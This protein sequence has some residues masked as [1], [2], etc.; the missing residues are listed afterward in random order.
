MLVVGS[1]REVSSRHGTL[2][3]LGLATA[4]KL[5]WLKECFPE[6][7]SERIEYVYDRT[8]KRV[9]A[10]RYLRFRDLIVAQ[11]HQKELDPKGSAA[12]LAQAHVEGLFELPLFSHDLKQFAARVNLIASAAPDLEFPPYDMDA[13]KRA[14]ARAFHGL[15]LAKEAQ[16]ADLRGAIRAHLA[17]EQ[18]AWVDELAPISIAWPGEKKLKLLYSEEGKEGPELQVKLHECFGAAEHPRICEGR[19]PVKV[20]LCSP[21]GKRIASTTDWPAFRTR[22]YPKIKPG[23]Q[24]KFP[25]FT[26]L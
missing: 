14:L 2:T 22:E 23:L 26:W 9:A 10:I 25:G 8:H 18:V 16:A 20:W 1:M 19:V 4:V 12:A 3:L 24:K 6:Q 5:E 7:F 13:V 17:P 15:T 11:E 21:D